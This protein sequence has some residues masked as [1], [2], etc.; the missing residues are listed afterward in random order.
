MN[1]TAAALIGIAFTIAGAIFGYGKLCAQVE[2]VRED[3]KAVS[4]VQQALID[5][6]YTAQMEMNTRMYEYM[7]EKDDGGD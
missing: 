7:L 1:K 4:G 6:F 3:V 2:D 5:K